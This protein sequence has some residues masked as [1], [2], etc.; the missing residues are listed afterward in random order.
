LACAEDAY[1]D[2]RS[3]AA[4]LV[5][6]L[7]N[8]VNRKEYA[9]AWDYYGD[10]KPAKTYDKFVQ[11]YAD[12]TRV[13]V[14]TG[15]VSEE[16]AAGSVFY[17]VPV[18]IRATDAKGNEAVFAGCYTARLANPQIQEPPFRPMHI[19]KGA[20][21]PNTDGGPLSSVLP[22]SCGEVPPTK[23]DA[24]RDDVIKAF[25]QAYGTTCDT[26]ADAKPEADEPEVNTLKFRYSYDTDADPEHE[27]TLFKFECSA[28]AYNFG[29]V[30]YLADEMG[31]RQLQ[32]AEPELDI[33]Y[34]DPDEQTKLKSMTIIGYETTDQLVNSFYDDKEMSLTSFSKWRGVGDSSS[35]GKWIFRNG[36]FTLVHYEVDPTSDGEINPEPVVNF[37][38]AP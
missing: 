7:Y 14:A 11:G 9:R 3:D 4:S 2:N 33:R 20:L 36:R 23:A 32:F 6:S 13:D 29:Q 22:E 28:G 18:A 17:Q 27:A 16:G 10:Q 24:T 21:K 38:E 19:E 25:K 30:F 31:F 12:T 15:A 8:A 26:L 34:D 1:L 37:E 5:R 35:N